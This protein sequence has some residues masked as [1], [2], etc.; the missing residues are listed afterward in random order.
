MSVWWQLGIGVVALWLVLRFVL[1][2]FS[3]RAPSEALGIRMLILWRVCRRPRN[4]VRK[5]DLAR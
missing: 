4:A 2:R 5:I 1:S 3:P